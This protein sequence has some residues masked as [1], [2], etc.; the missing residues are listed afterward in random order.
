MSFA[1]ATPV[2]RY[3][4][5]LQPENPEII[6]GEGGWPDV[7]PKIAR[8]VM[9]LNGTVTLERLVESIENAIQYIQ[10]ELAEWKALQ[11]GDLG[12]KEKGLYLRAVY[13]TAK[14]DLTER[15]RD[16]DT[17]GDGERRVEDLVDAVDDA[18]RNVRWAISDILNQPRITVEAL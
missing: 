9:R 6:S 4:L 12:P 17:T 8:I 11:M 1:S 2:P 18:R 13:F 16:F 14:A 15:Y 3:P 10:S 5:T 7:D